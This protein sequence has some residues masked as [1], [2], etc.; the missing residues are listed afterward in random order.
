[1]DKSATRGKRGYSGFPTRF[2]MRL[3]T[4][5]GGFAQVHQM[6]TSGV[7][8][9]ALA[10]SMGAK[11][12]HLGFLA[13]IPH[14]TQVFQL[15]GA[16]L[17]EATRRRKLIAVLSAGISRFAWML[18]PLFYL[19]EDPSAALRWLLITVIVASCMELV[20]NNAW[21]TWM[22]DLIPESL[23]GRYFGFRRGV[24]AAVTIGV[25]LLGGLWLDW[26][27]NAFSHEGAMTGILL[28]AA[29]GG[30]VSV[31]LL[32]RQ[33]DI[34][35]PVERV[36]PKVRDLLLQPIRNVQFRRALEFFLLWNVAIG[37][38]AA[39]FNLHMIQQL[40]MSFLA[41]GIFQ[42]IKPFIGLFLFKRW[43][44]ILDHFQA[45]SVL[46]ITGA[47]ITTLP[48][49]WLLP[50][51]GHLAA[52]GVVA[53]ISGIAWTGFNVSVYTY[54]MHLSPRIGRSY[55]LAYFSIIS[56]LGFVL[57]AFA[58]GLVAQSME[59]WRLVVGERTFMVFHLMFVI[60]A[61]I[62]LVSLT[63]L[64]RLRELRIPGTIALINHIGGELWRMGALGR[65]FPRWIRKITSSGKS[66]A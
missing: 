25:S 43:G 35:R 63:L 39:F 38:T 17:V 30:L 57:A 3:S 5:E 28:L 65:P 48:L 56:G 34:P 33:P 51:E 23:R 8:L 55:Y 52:L 11:P 14:L 19:I 29:T 44:R 13:A 61:G 66:A 36:A 53:V 26:G 31:A 9:T 2:L 21:T 59:N 32:K 62:R 22:A 7:F 45:R 46:L 37:F 18:I 60:S 4:V 27:S 20:S 41:I 58:G 10:L 50:T 12:W 16:Y 24:L 42:A 15:L 54:P 6:L 1:M 64:F 47:M 40:K 49:I